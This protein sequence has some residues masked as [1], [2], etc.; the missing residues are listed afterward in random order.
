MLKYIENS[1]T[2]IPLCES[3]FTSGE[4][5]IV[6]NGYGLVLQGFKVIGFSQPCQER[7]A[8]IHLDWDCYW[9]SLPDSRVFKTY[10]LSSFYRIYSPTKGFLGLDDDNSLIWLSNSQ[11]S[12]LYSQTTKDNFSATS[13]CEN[14]VADAVYVKALDSEPT[15]D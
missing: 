9:F 15:R 6:V 14:G 10:E 4:E 2:S 8:Y 3:R 1:L 11:H 5:V 7:Q 12:E 13:M